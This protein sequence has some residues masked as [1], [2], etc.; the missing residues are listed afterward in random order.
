MPMCPN[1]CGVNHRNG[2]TPSNCINYPTL[3]NRRG[4]AEVNSSADQLMNKPVF[5][6]GGAGVHLTDS[7]REEDRQFTETF[8][9]EHNDE[10]E[11]ALG[12]EAGEIQGESEATEI[13]WHFDQLTAD[14]SE[15]RGEIEAHDSDEE[16]IRSYAESA[17]ENWR[18][19]EREWQQRHRKPTKD[20]WD[21]YRA[22]RAKDDRHDRLHGD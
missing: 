6:G 3:T 19:E 20:E 2:P 15:V 8:M 21:D 11:E 7:E 1:G 22:E 18:A 4:G 13:R 17:V 9:R 14:P 12:E 10:I 5:T 16:F